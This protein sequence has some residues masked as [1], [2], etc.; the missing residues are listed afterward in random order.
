M[1]VSKK[2]DMIYTS[3]EHE[4]CAT[5]FGETDPAHRVETQA[6]MV[7]MKLRHTQTGETCGV[8]TCQH[9]ESGKSIILYDE[10]LELLYVC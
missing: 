10:K 8:I 9:I 4:I 1:K 2:L 6:K 5:V 7:Q 3:S